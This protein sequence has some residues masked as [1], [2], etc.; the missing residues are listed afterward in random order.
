MSLPL[1]TKFTSSQATIWTALGIDE[2]AL[3]YA[4]LIV[5]LHA[6]AR[7]KVIGYVIV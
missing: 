4:T 5:A 7:G 1:P 3:Q 2:E 6:C